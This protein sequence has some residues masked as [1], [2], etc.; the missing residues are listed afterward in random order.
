M[1]GTKLGNLLTDIYLFR[2]PSGW[3]LHLLQYSYKHL[4]RTSTTISRRDVLLTLSNRESAS[5]LRNW[6]RNKALTYVTVA[7]YTT[8]LH[9]C[10]QAS[11]CWEWKLIYLNRCNCTKNIMLQAK[12]NYT[13]FQV[14]WDF[15]RLG[16]V[17]LNIN[18]IRHKK[19]TTQA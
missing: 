17:L 10:S 4:E 11:I 15:E 9:L 2:C 6:E 13:Q 1:E 16:S 19:Y 8:R 3:L 5:V 7:Y 18:F 14:V 12:C